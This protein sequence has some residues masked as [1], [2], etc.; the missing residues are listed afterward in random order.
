VA[1]LLDDFSVGELGDLGQGV[2]GRAVQL[3]CL[4]SCGVVEADLFESFANIDCLIY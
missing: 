3:E 4:T 2:I 1:A